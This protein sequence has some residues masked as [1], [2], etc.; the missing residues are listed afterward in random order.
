MVDQINP[1]MVVIGVFLIFQGGKGT[2]SRKLDLENTVDCSRPCFV[3]LLCELSMSELTPAGG[4]IGPEKVA[5]AAT[6]GGGETL[7]TRRRRR[8]RK[9]GGGGGGGGGGNEPNVASDKTA[10]VCKKSAKYKRCYSAAT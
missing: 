7:Y 6:T 8:R 3:H 2:I 10:A 5:A 1:R 4:L 9:K